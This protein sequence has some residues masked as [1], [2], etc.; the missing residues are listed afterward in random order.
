MAKKHV[1]TFVSTDPVSKLERFAEEVSNYYHLDDTYFGNVIICLDTLRGYCQKGYREESW[2]LT[3]HVRSAREGLVFSI[4]D[5]G[6]VISASMVPECISVDL[7]DREGGEFLFTLGT[8]SDYFR[9]NTA[10]REVELVFST[11]SMH[12]ELS[13]KRAEL[14]KEYFQSDL[15]IKKM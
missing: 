1:L 7:L 13:L 10:T 15:V 3:I 12:R 14:L 5:R 6:G 11:H 2:E 4:L 9:A 8:L